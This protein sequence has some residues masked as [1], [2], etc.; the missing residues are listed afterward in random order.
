MDPPLFRTRTKLQA[1]SFF[2]SCWQTKTRGLRVVLSKGLSCVLGQA[3]GSGLAA[4]SSWGGRNNPASRKPAGGPGELGQ[5]QHLSLCTR[6][7]WKGGR[8]CRLVSPLQ[9]K[10]NPSYFTKPQCGVFWWS[11]TLPMESSFK[12]GL[13]IQNLVWVDKTLPPPPPFQTEGCS[14]I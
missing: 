2:I 8:W 3:P 7:R 1:L 6:L 9:W 11:V 14:D 4:R 12:T 13:S 5:R 10:Q